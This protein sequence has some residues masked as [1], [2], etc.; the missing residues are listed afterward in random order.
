MPRPREAVRVQ[1][2]SLG[3]F[4]VQDGGRVSVEALPS[5]QAPAVELALRRQARAIEFLQRGLAVLHASAV[6]VG[7]TAVAFLGDSGAGKSTSAA[8]LCQR[9]HALIGDDLVLIDPALLEMLDSTREPLRLRD[10]VLAALEVEP[11]TLPR[12]DG[13]KRELQPES[14]AAATRCGRIRIYVLADGDELEPVRIEALDPTEALFVLARHSPAGALARLG[15]S[16]ATLSVLALI[17]RHVPVGRLVRPRDLG[18]LSSLVTAV[19]E[20]CRRALANS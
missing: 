11:A 7:D 2:D 16:A 6:A 8:S 4:V 15:G 1:I 13:D 12:V 18:R 17:A 14:A 5:A 10:D 9:G 20:D 3:S 19:E